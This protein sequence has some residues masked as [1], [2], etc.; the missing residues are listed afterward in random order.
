MRKAL[1]VGMIGLVAPV[2]VLAIYPL[3]IHTDVALLLVICL[4]FIGSILLLFGTAIY[5][6]VD[7]FSRK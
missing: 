1:I 7:K 3:N 4:V 2:A 6:V 5:W